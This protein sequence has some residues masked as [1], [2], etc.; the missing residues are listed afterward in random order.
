MRVSGDHIENIFILSEYIYQ[1]E[2]STG[3]F[4]SKII[5]RLSTG[6]QH[7]SVMSPESFVPDVNN[8]KIP[9]VKYHVFSRSKFNKNKLLPRLLGQMEQMLRFVKLLMLYFKKDDV[10]ITGTNPVVLLLI[11]PF[12]HLILRFRWI[13][14]VHDV[15]PDNLVPSK[16][17]NS[18]SLLLKA[19]QV[20]FRWVYRSA[21]LIVV[22][23]RDMKKLIEEKV[24]SSEKIHYIPNWV[25]EN[26]IH[27]LDR[28]KSE[29]ITNLGWGGKFVF[30]FFGNIG[31]LQAVD[32]L[33]EAIRLVK[34]PSAV[35]L[36]IGGGA[37]ANLI[38]EFVSGNSDNRVHYFGE[39]EQSRKII[40]LAACDI[41]LIT[42][43]K[44]M[45]GLGVPSKAYFS[46]AADRPLLAVMEPDAE[47]ALM[48]K[49]HNIG[50]VCDPGNPVALAA[51]IEKI[52]AMPIPLKIASSRHVFES[53]FSERIGL[54]RF[55]KILLDF[56]AQRRNF[57]S[58]F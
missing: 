24:G 45:V 42:L 47:I 34:N 26:D 53:H 22:I 8:E 6:R 2:N 50:W 15:Y 40:G 21:D 39:L 38:K 19:L 18:K 51:L 5:E 32:N 41:A 49:E 57:H 52:C 48:V 7:L 14:I 20:Y 9:G 35:F 12:F 4:W 17:L 43:E 13:L 11:F 56:S 33:L 16:V 58:G 54:E 27:P 30:Q 44:G 36:F 10:V 37:K 31:R 29:I 25:D 28:N 55:E 23:G 1:A 46:M 3:Y